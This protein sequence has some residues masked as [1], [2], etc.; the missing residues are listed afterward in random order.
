M[1]TSL[2]ELLESRSVLLADGATGTNYMERGLGPGE[3]P[4]LWNVEHPERVLALHQEFVDAGSDI[5]LTNTFGCS[6]NRL[7]LHKAESRVFELA[8][9]A[10]A[11]AGQIAADSDRPVA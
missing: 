2:A 9:A 4:E 11:L 8:K 1:R 7:K 6:S 5:I 3:P 10:G